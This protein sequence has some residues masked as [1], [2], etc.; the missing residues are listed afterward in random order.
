[1]EITLNDVKKLVAIQSSLAIIAQKE[2]GNNQ[3]GIAI[4]VNGSVIPRKDWENYL[5]KE[6]DEVLIIKATQGGWLWMF[7][8]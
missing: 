1:M 6:N 5:L 3:N 4:A 7:D 8:V 2:I